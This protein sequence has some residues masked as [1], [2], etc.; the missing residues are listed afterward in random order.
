[1]CGVRE[2]KLEHGT[3]TALLVT[4]SVFPLSYASY[5]ERSPVN[6]YINVN[7]PLLYHIRSV[8]STLTVSQL[9]RVKHVADI[10]N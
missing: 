10:P 2:D 8:L 7:G 3:G 6:L 9:L 5:D 1:M 4:K